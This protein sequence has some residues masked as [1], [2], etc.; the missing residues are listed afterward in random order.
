MRREMIALQEEM[1][2]LVYAAY[3]LLSSDHPAIGNLTNPA[4]LALGERAFELKRDGK[5]IPTIWSAERRALWQARLDAIAN[6]EHIR[7]MEQ[8]VYK[9]RW[10]RKISDDQEFRRAFEWWLL[11]KAE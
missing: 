7:R 10:Y 2:W 9:W 11:E 1:D 6:N 5:P 3:G 4:P 8:P